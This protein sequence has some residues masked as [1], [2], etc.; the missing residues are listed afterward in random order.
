MSDRCCVPQSGSNESASHCPVCESPGRQVE[1]ITLKALLRPAALMRLSA[2]AH[3]FCPTAGCMVVY[4]GIGEVF[5]RGDVM[6]PVF[7][8]E[9]PGARTVCYC[10]ALTEEDIRR[11]LTEAGLSSASERITQLV[12]DERCACEVRN[13]QGNCCLGNVA[14]VTKAM[15]A[16]LREEVS[17]EV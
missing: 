6:V 13:P 15:D 9:S 12:K 10:F 2:P 5:E 14:E 3:R 7:Q 16:A 17:R 4:F 11:E 8:K 1:R